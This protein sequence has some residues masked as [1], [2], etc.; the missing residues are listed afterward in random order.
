VKNAKKRLPQVL[1]DLQVKRQIR[2]AN[3]GNIE[4]VFCKGCGTQIVG[5]VEAEEPERVEK[6]NKRT[7]V[8]KRLLA[9]R[10]PQYREVRLFF[11]D[12]T[13]HITHCCSACVQKILANPQEAWKQDMAQWAEDER[14]GLGNVRWDRYIDR[15][16]VDAEEVTS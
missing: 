11:T 7:V 12:Q 16:V 9:A 1:A 2:Y 6:I 5:L 4:A 10:S 8:Y 3:G 15:E 13:A 14:R